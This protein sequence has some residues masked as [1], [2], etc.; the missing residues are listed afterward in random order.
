MLTI[1]HFF[2]RGIWVRFGAIFQN[3][4]FPARFHRLSPRLLPLL[5]C[6]FGNVV[7]PP[8]IIKPTT[9]SLSLNNPS[10]AA[11]FFVRV[12]GASSEERLLPTEHSSRPLSSCT[13]PHRCSAFTGPVASSVRPA[14]TPSD[15]GI[16]KKTGG[17]FGPSVFCCSLS[18]SIGWLS[19]P[20]VYHSV[21]AA[22]AEPEIASPLFSTRE[23]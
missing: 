3:L 6:A 15:I 13:A 22:A 21:A 4:L 9:L 18:R 12:R 5:R 10:E 7:V 19:A 11:W 20:V 2:W 14:E 8:P 16:D 1:L 17:L 23:R